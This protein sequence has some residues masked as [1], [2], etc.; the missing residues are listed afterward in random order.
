MSSIH[1][2]IVAGPHYERLKEVVGPVQEAMVLLM[3]VV[4]SMQAAGLDEQS[5]H[6]ILVINTQTWDKSCAAVGCEI[7]P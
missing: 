6:D 4:S 3:D 2:E 7:L 1:D 5:I